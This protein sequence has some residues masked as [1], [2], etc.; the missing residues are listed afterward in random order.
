MALKK[1][2][3]NGAS[4]SYYLKGI[5][6]DLFKINNLEIAGP[7]E[8]NKEKT[9]IT[10]EWDGSTRNFIRIRIIITDVP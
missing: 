7:R 1:Q 4:Y 9:K 10:K 3:A 2:M 6:R 5:K 8:K